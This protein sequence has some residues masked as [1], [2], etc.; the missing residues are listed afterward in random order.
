MVKAI[1]IYNGERIDGVNGGLEL[2]PIEMAIFVMVTLHLRGGSNEY[3]TDL[4]LTALLTQGATR[5]PRSPR[6]QQLPKSQQMKPHS[7]ASSVSS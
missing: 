1:T 4:K 7:R 6:T 2:L 5:I 3:F